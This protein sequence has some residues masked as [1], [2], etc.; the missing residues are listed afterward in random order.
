MISQINTLLLNK[1]NIA[2][3]Q[4]LPW[5]SSYLPL[6]PLKATHIFMVNRIDAFCLLFYFIKELFC[7]TDLNHTKD[8]SYKWLLL[9]MPAYPENLRHSKAVEGA[10]G[11]RPAWC[12]TD[13]CQ[14]DITEGRLQTP[15]PFFQV[16]VILSDCKNHSP[17][18][19]PLAEQAEIA[20]SGSAD[21]C[22]SSPNSYVWTSKFWYF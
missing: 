21:I 19:Q 10:P 5:L 9:S 4:K 22:S 12:W 13:C 14:S 18:P 2:R 15:R 16:S 8:S 17:N 7:K 1:H 11:K 6:P 3:T 20:N